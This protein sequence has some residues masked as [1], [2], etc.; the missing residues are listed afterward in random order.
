MIENTEFTPQQMERVEYLKQLFGQMQQCD[1]DG[2]LPVGFSDKQQLADAV[3][4]SLAPEAEQL[5]LG[6]LQYD[7]LNLAVKLAYPE[8][9][10]NL[11]Q[12]LMDSEAMCENVFKTFALPI[13]SMLDAAGIEY[14]FQYRMKSV[15]SIWRK[16][17]I[18]NKYFDDVYDLFA[19][20]IVYKVPENLHPLAASNK[21]SELADVHNDMAQ[22]QADM[23][24]E[25]LT[26]WRIYNILSM[27]YRIHPGRIKDWITKPKPS[28]YQALQMTVMG[29]DCNWIEIQIRSERMDYEAEYGSAAHWR[30]K[31][32]TA[33][34]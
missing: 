18:D 8:D 27:L 6:K 34:K 20:R 3:M 9:Y 5:G 28:G 23:D 30:Y 12:L 1:T 22:L 10:K 2:T 19:T 4:E 33:V 17:R 31:A 11:K 24:K 29:P 32:E 25:I 7:M 13:R 21:V 26:C 16:M 14:A 15:Y